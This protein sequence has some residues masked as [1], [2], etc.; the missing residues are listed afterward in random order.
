MTL[1][2]CIKHLCRLV[3][4]CTYCSSFVTAGTFKGI[5][6]LPVVDGDGPV[7]QTSKLQ[8]KLDQVTAILLGYLKGSLFCCFLSSSFLTY[9]PEASQDDSLKMSVSNSRTTTEVKEIHLKI[10]IDILKCEANHRSIFFCV[11]DVFLMSKKAWCV[12]KLQFSKD[13]QLLVWYSTS[14]LESYCD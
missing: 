6:S 11:S 14:E 8:E 10:F 12:M 9:P 5:H 1:H 2:L 4:P 3:L 13:I 7:F